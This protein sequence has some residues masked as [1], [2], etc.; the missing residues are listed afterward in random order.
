[1]KHQLEA[2]GIMLEFGSRRTLSGIYIRCETGKITGILGR[3]GTGKSCL[4][5]IIYGSL[6]AMSKS[7]RFDHVSVNHAYKRPDLLTYLPQHHFIPSF[8][9][10]K[11]IFSHF[12]LEYH[13]FEL[14]FP[15][16]TSKYKSRIRDLSGGQ[17]R[18]IEVYIIIK[19]KSAFS[20]LDEPFSH[21]TPLQIDT[22][23]ELLS[24]E[25]QRKGFLITDHLFHQVTDI[26]DSL[27]VLKEGIS[28]LTKDIS[29]IEK[30]GYVRL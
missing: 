24:R 21:I 13:D 1:M 20:M 14:W 23:K 7:V 6:P 18:L 9:S 29:D 5:N 12:D 8:L 28:Y 4:M 25:K 11:S 10:V 15:E 19:A 27:Y 3:N 30:L 2:D 22:I 16:F 26:C 17:R